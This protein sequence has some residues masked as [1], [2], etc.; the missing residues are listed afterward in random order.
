MTI[1]W[2]SISVSS[3]RTWTIHGCAPMTRSGWPF[4]TLAKPSYSLWWAG[5]AK[6][7]GTIWWSME[8]GQGGD[9]DEEKRE[10]FTP[11]SCCL[12]YACLTHKTPDSR[13]KITEPHPG[14]FSDHSSQ[15]WNTLLF[16]E[17]TNQMPLSGTPL[18]CM[19]LGAPSLHL[20]NLHPSH[21][22]RDSQLTPLIHPLLWSPT[23]FT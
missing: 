10:Q 20:Q 5:A 11:P 22:K 4:T 19:M 12:I 16:C 13:Y 1:L 7:K 15:N 2:V 14:G 18:I 6:V 3:W 23:L 8:G 9:K 21:Q 17:P